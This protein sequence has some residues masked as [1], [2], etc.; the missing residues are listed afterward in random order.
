MTVT[1]KDAVLLVRAQRAV[2]DVEMSARRLWVE[3]LA[4][5][6]KVTDVHERMLSLRELVDVMEVGLTVLAEHMLAGEIAE[7]RAEADA[8]G[9]PTDEVDEFVVRR[10]EEQD[11]ADVRLARLIAA[12]DGRAEGAPLASA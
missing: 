4:F 3:A 6:G 12:G 8:L 9:V 5:G 1:R 10:I 7:L 2:E 11:D